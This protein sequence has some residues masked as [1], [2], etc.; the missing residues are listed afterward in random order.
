M[1][2]VHSPRTGTGV[3]FIWTGGIA[4]VLG[5]L[6]SC[7]ASSTM[8]A[9]M[10]AAGGMMALFGG[11]LISIGFVVGLVHKMELR[12]VDIQNDLRQTTIMPTVDGVDEALADRDAGDKAQGTAPIVY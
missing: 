6:V 1:K 4:L 12:L 2:P 3:P 5:L 8:D 11:A 10:A 9:G 7:G